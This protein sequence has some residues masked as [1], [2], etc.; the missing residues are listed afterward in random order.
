MF[1]AGHK[2]MHPEPR[3]KSRAAP[4]Q[5]MGGGGITSFKLNPTPQSVTPVIET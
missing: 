2:F 5:L 4:S 3:P 1:L